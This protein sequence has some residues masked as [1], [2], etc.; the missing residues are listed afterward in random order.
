MKASSWWYTKEGNNKINLEFYRAWR[1]V[2]DVL[3]DGEFKHAPFI[4]EQILGAEWE[5]DCA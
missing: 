3:Y 4:A 5:V 1:S 2:S